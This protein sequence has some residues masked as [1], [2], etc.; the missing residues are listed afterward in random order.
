MGSNN[1]LPAKHAAG[2]MSYRW[3]SAFWFAAFAWPW[4]GLLGAYIGLGDQ[5][6]YTVFVFAAS[7]FAGAFVGHLILGGYRG[8]TRCALSGGAAPWFATLFGT[9][10][11]GWGAWGTSALHEF[12]TIGPLFTLPGVVYGAVY[13]VIHEAIRDK[14]SANVS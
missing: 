6:W 5:S 3:T 2:P 9:V 11:T 4:A 10:M 13:W 12:A 7:A 8:L 14:R 1:L